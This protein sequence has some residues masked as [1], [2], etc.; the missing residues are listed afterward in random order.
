MET[1]DKDNAS[2]GAWKDSGWNTGWADPEE[3][4]YTTT[5]ATGYFVITVGKKDDSAL[6]QAELDNIH[7]MFK[8]E[9]NKATEIAGS[10]NNPTLN[11][12]MVSVNHRGWYE[13]PENTLAA[14]RES[15]NRGFRYV[16]CDVQFTKDGT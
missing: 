16:E 10:V 9:G 12:P 6:T 3:R 5:Y 15:Y 2:Q 8:V 7:S 13:A 1:T 4:T 11:D 14:Y